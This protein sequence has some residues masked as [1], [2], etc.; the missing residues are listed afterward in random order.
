MN[1]SDPPLFETFK[2]YY[3]QT[4]LFFGSLKFAVVIILI[5]AQ[6]LGVGTYMES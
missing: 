4:E 2:Y 1:Q 6:S 3:K 5:F